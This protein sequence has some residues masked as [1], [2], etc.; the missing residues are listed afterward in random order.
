MKYDVEPMFSISDQVEKGKDLF[1]ELTLTEQMYSEFEQKP[2]WEFVLIPVEG[3]PDLFLNGD[4]LPEPVYGNYRWTSEMLKAQERIIVTN[5]ECTEASIGCKKFF[6]RVTTEEDTA[7]SFILVA[8]ANSRNDQFFLDINVPFSGQVAKGEIINFIVELSPEIP[9]KLTSNIDLVSNPGGNSDLYVMDCKDRA[10]CFITQEMINKAAKLSEDKKNY[11]GYSNDLEDYDAVGF[12]MMIKPS[13][14][15]IIGN[16]SLYYSKNNMFAVAV[17]GNSLNDDPESEGF[18]LRFNTNGY[19]MLLTEDAE[20]KFIVTT[21]TRKMIT[22][23]SIR[24]VDNVEELQFNFKVFSGDLKIYLKKGSKP[25]QNDDY[26]KIMVVKNNEKELDAHSTSFQIIKDSNSDNISGSYFIWFEADTTA[27]V[28]I[29]AEYIFNPTDSK[30]LPSKILKIDSHSDRTIRRPSDFKKA[31]KYDEYRVPLDIVKGETN[32]FV[33]RLESMIGHLRMCVVATFKDLD[34]SLSC[35]ELDGEQS[36]DFYLLTTDIPYYESHSEVHIRIE[37][38]F[39]DEDSEA[40]FNALKYETKDHETEKS[41]N[42]WFR[43]TLSASETKGIHN[44]GHGTAFEGNIQPDR[45]DYLVYEFIRTE[46]VD[47]VAINFEV[48]DE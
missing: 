9:Q 6:V 28:E 35:M 24:P 34:N 29:N 10:S 18:Y 25:L 26:D 27:L 23:K 36:S 30:D 31:K 38:I 47:F 40:K 43:Y 22:F 13:E 45:P 32:E 14:S 46:D 21:G 48:Y 1:Y 4:A 5:K 20:Q 15:K 2:N 8:V 7:S 44:L 12:E 42:I 19:E 3:D 11:F 33:F 17:V 41:D 39:K 37:P 16:E